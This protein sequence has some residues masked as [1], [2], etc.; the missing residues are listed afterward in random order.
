MAGDDPFGTGS[1]DDRTRL[2]PRPGGSRH[3]TQAS[4]APPPR[5][6]APGQVFEAFS[7]AVGAN[8]LLTAATPLL[9]L[10]TRLVETVAHPDPD[11]LRAQ[12]AQ[13]VKAF[14]DRAIARGIPSDDV[15]VA[16]YVLCTALDEAALHTPWG[17]ASDWPQDSLLVSFHGEA[18]GGDKF[19][20]LLDR[21]NR[22]PGRNL[23]LLELMYTCLS[24]GFQ[25][26]YR[27]HP[28]GQNQLAEIREQLY[29][30]LRRL[31]ERPERE[32]SPHWHGVTER[33]NVLV[34]HVPLWVVAVVGLGLLLALYWFFSTSLNQRSDPVALALSAVEGKQVIVRAEPERRLAPAPPPPPEPSILPTLR[35][36]LAEDIAAG[37]VEVIDAGANVV[38]R[39][40]GD[41]VFASGRAAVK[42][43]LDPTLERIAAALDLVPGPILVTGHTDSVPIRTIRFPSNFHLSQARADSVAS[44]LSSM[45]ISP[46][47]LAA[48]GRAHNERLEKPDDTRD[49]RAR[50]RRVEILV[51]RRPVAGRGAGQ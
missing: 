3:R 13:E 26:R 42:S 49:K 34:R 45:L 10:L 23:P 1:D 15:F 36:L 30:T 41:G 25:G 24:L 22:D 28:D 2:V 12:I 50:N 31:R 43:S 20:A 48:K 51:S 6:V 46:G 47:R 33:Q 4:G 9:V 38:I 17:A 37:R 21:S 19:F 16:R 35:E 32:L 14:D 18:D 8:A 44:K 27:V 11:G 39:L 40:R 29:Q 5:Q 7:S